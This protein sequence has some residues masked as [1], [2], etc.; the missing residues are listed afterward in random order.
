MWKCP[1]CEEN[2]EDHYDSCWKCAE[3]TDDPLCPS[4]KQGTI[5]KG[6]FLGG[7]GFGPV[8][9]LFSPNGQKKSS[10]FPI[11]RA[12]EFGPEGFLCVTCG[13]VWGKVDPK[14]AKKM[15]EQLGRD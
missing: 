6:Y 11:P 4:C 2:H 3:V 8:G 15:V 5:L 1:K 14:E 10:F 9:G 7:E 13:M 12:I